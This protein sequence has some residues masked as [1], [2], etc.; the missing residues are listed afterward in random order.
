MQEEY[1]HWRIGIVGE[2]NPDEYLG[3]I[4]RV[5]FL[6]TGE[7]YIGKKQFHR[8]NKAGTKRFGPSDWKKYTTSS[9]HINGLLAEYPMECFCFEIVR[10]CQTKSILSYAESNILHKLDALITVD[11][12]W[13]LPKYLN[14]RI[15][16][17][18]WIT[19]NYPTGD[20]NSLIRLVLSFPPLDLS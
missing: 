13:G 4:Y 7:E 8:M 17:V 6:L 1:G 16:P 15:D 2:F 14:K 18:R 12:T 10:L 3:F 11:N 9:E 19:K 5:T 20:V